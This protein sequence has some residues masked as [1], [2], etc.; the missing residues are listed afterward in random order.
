MHQIDVGY[1]LSLPGLLF[2]IVVF[3]AYWLPTF[4]AFLRNIKA[5]GT[6]LLLN[7][8]GFLVVPWAIALIFAITARRIEPVT[9]PPASPPAA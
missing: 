7:L 8:F 2:S 4:L 9:P 6:V 3:A 1:H 5:K